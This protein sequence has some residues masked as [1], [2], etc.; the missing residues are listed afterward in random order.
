M[1]QNIHE[2]IRTIR[3]EQQLSIQ[4]LSKLSGVSASHISR[5]ERSNRKPSADTLQKLAPHLQVE[6][7]TLLKV[8]DLYEEEQNKRIHLDQLLKEPHLYFEGSLLKPDHAKQVFEFIKE[9]QKKED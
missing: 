9:L 5:I 7:D 1:S 8:A 4:A 6:Y 3:I 2:F